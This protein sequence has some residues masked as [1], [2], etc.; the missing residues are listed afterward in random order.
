MAAQSIEAF[1]QAL[2]V[3]EE[4]LNTEYSFDKAEPSYLRCLE[5]IDAAPHLRPQIVALLIELFREKKISDEPVAF[6]MH[7]LRWPEIRE[8]AEAQLVGMRNP[9]ANG[10]ALEKV[11]MAYSDGWENKEFYELFR[12]NAGLEF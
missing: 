9:M 12:L 5:I 4:V 10:R 6:L 7:R 2:L 8:W 3:S 11:L 1:E